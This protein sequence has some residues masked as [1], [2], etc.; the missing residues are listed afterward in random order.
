MVVRRSPSS[1]ARDARALTDVVTQ[2]RRALRRSIRSD[3]PWELRP[4]AQIEVLQSIAETGPVRVGDL[5]DRLRLAQ[6]TVSA[7]V[8][9][10]IEARLVTRDADPDDRR[11]SVVALTAAGRAAIRQ[12]DEAHR[13]RLQR[14]LRGLPAADRDTVLGAVAALERLVRQLDAEP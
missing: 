2:L 10:L 13:A 9:K 6:S 7:L 5:V 3:Y 8:G 1:T 12:W 11:A 4:M 14:A